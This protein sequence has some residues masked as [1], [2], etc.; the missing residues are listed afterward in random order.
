MMRRYK[1]ENPKSNLFQEMIAE[2][3]IRVHIWEQ[4]IADRRYFFDG[5]TTDYR[6][7]GDHET[8]VSTDDANRKLRE[9]KELMPLIQR[10]KTDYL[11]LALANNVNLN[12]HGDVRNVSSL[13]GA[14]DETERQRLD[15]YKDNGSSNAR[16]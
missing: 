9:F 12:I 2:S 8:D 1:K 13:F 4:R 3:L 5:E 16:I 11:K 10:W 15:A 14:L 6:Q 7:T